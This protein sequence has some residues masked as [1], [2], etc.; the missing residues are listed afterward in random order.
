MKLIKEMICQMKDELSGAEEYAI[1]ALEYQSQKLQ[2][3]NLYHQ[4][5]QVELQHYASLHE[6]IMNIIEENQNKKDVPEEMILKWEEKHRKLI[7]K[8]AKIQTYINMF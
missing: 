1:M 8:V 5:S 4:M 7:A 6:Q 3:A 2:L